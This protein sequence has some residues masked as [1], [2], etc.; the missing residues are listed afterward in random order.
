M[1]VDVDMGGFDS[2]SD[3][4]Q[5]PRR[6]EERAG[7]NIV[8]IGASG[9]G[10]S[11]VGWLLAR[12]VGFGF[13]DL[14]AAIESREKK[15]I[16]QIFDEKGESYFRE[17]ERDMVASLHGMRSHVIATGGGAVADDA[18]WGLLKHMGVT[19]W[20]NPPPEEIARRLSADEAELQKR[21]LLAEL[22][23]HKDR[24]TRHK[25]MSERIKALTGNRADKYKQARVTI[26][27]SFST[28]E[29]TARLVRDI[30]QREG[31]LTAPGKDN[32]P[33]DRWRIL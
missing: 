21:P 29:S 8:L 31:L 15:T 32:R 26:S 19:V 33:Y 30:L 9:S 1:D 13:V 2:D 20:L 25:L 22:L 6:D 16:Q 7:S 11:A 5:E 4:E 17:V 14:D 3:F 12:L 24:E 18:S 10:K 27:D 23:T 28:P